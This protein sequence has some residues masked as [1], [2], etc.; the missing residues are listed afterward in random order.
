MYEPGE[1]IS[2]REMCDAEGASLQRGMNFR[3]HGSESVIL[4]SLRPNAPYRDRI[5]DAGRILMY[6]GHDVSK[7]AE[8]DPKTIDQPMRTPNGRLTQNGLFWEAAQNYGTNGA[9]AEIVRV[10]EKIRTGIWVF[11]GTFRLIGARFEQSGPR[12]V[13]EFRLEVSASAGKEPA[14][15][16]ALEHERFIPSHVKIAVWKR[17]KGRC[18]KC[19][20]N[21]NLHFDHVIPFSLGGSSIIEENIQL[22]CA[23]HNLQKRDRLE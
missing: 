11:N 10:Y 9:S 13:F 7:T 23:R 15:I 1:I 19:G 2:Y 16:V 20:S 3:H 18:V 21:D 22:M 12:K 6:E 4:M 17:D 5:E 14:G 8:K